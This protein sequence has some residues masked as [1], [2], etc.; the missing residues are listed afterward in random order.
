[1]PQSSVS[2]PEI[3]RS[4]Y[5]LVI[6]RRFTDKHELDSTTLR[7][8]SPHLL[9]VFREVVGSTYT[10]VA[11]D[12]RSP[13]EM[14]SPFQMLMHYWD[15]LEQY[16]DETEDNHVRQHLKLLFDFM[17]HEL[18]PD[19]KSVTGM[20][21][22]GRINYT[23][24][25]VL[26]RPGGLVYASVMGHPWLLQCQKTAYEES[27]IKGPYI[28]VTCTYTDHDGALEGAAVHKFTIFQ[29]EHFGAENP[30]FITDLPV[31]PRRFAGEAGTLEARLEE[32]GRN[33]LARRTVC[34]QAYNGIAQYLKEPPELFYNPEMAEFDG[35][36]LPFTESGRIILD[37]KTF[38]EDQYS[39]QVSI[40]AM[41]PDP[42]LCPPY[43][44]GYSLSRKDW[45]R[46][47]VDN[48]RDVEWKEGVWESLVLP[49]E[50]K[51]VL[52][53]LV[54]SH[55][56]PDD[57]RDQPELKGKGLIFLLHGSPGSGKTLTA[58][59][60]AEGTRKALVS[61]SLGD[62]NRYDSP[63][64]FEIRLKE[65]LS[66]ATI[67]RAVVLLDEADVFLEARHSLGD[68]TTRNAL[69]AVFLRELEYFSGIIFLTT[70][71]LT[72]FDAAMKSRIHL[73]L[74][75]SLPNVETRRQIWMNLLSSMPTEGIDI[76]DI[77]DAVVNLLVE[78]LN[79]R[80]ISN[81]F[82]TAR[83]IARSQNKRLNLEH[84]ERVI[85]VRNDF[86]RRLYHCV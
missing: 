75:Y 71:R 36:W 31:Y 19:R 72:T 45:C 77:D 79:G 64:A 67:W 42:L 41:T 9:G 5:A 20:V 15:E 62:L 7:I 33:F 8:N 21:L 23:H 24:S 12:F 54:T 46:F 66:Y 32:R 60:A 28:V 39:N 25:W 80:E 69:V 43:E 11:S 53:A 59:T 44:Y 14:T 6:Q 10:T 18:G 65:V 34:V 37:R 51:L 76:E 47:L 57:A 26:F 85:R 50:H 78:K 38:H 30:A 1:M 48:M 3:G 55:Q 63:R 82:S 27:T 83:T 40:K 16:R 61:S 17:D 22:N 68:S 58:E 13:F 4:S 35:V 70:N 56:Y 81:T 29:K 86:E 52:Q 49:T 84:I 2:L 73:A 74:E